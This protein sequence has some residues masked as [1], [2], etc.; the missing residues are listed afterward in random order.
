MTF[1]TDKHLRWIFIA[2][3]SVNAALINLLIEADHAR[4]L[5]AETTADHLLQRLKKNIENLTSTRQVKPSEKS[6]KHNLTLKTESP[7][8]VIRPVLQRQLG[9]V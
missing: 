5:V 9:V 4:R 7:G 2:F 8:E 1:F 3:I 6:C